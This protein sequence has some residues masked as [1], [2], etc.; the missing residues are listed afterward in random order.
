MPRQWGPT[1]GN[2]RYDA[3]D[4]SSCLDNTTKGHPPR[5]ASQ[6]LAR[7]AS[8]PYDG[9]DPPRR[10]DSEK[11]GDAGPGGDRCQLAGIELAHV[12]NRDLR[13]VRQGFNDALVGG[14]VEPLGLWKSC[15][16]G[17]QHTWGDESASSFFLGLL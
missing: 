16:H 13:F 8:V 7:C 12:F 6:R 15:V 17:L 2:V 3:I 14:T 4:H 11:L 5:P 9:A 1:G 10:E